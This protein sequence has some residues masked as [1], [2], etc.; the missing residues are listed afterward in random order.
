MTLRVGDKI[1][2]DGKTIVKSTICTKC[3]LKAGK[4]FADK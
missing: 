1:V 3:Y 4:E 2:L